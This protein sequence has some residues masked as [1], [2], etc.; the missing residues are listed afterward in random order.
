[1]P[2]SS[3]DQTPDPEPK[4]N[5]VAAR[6]AANNWRRSTKV[7]ER[8][9]RVA[10]LHERGLDQDTIGRR[11]GVSRSTI[12]RDLRRLEVLWRQEYAKIASAERLRS[13]AVHRATDDV[14][15]AFIERHHKDDDRIADVNATM[16]TLTASMREKRY[17][18]KDAPRPHPHDYWGYADSDT[19]LRARVALEEQYEPPANAI[20]GLISNEDD[21]PDDDPKLAALHELHGELEDLALAID[22]DPGSAAVGPIFD[23]VRRRLKSIRSDR[24]L[25]G[26]SGGT[27]D[28]PDPS[29]AAGPHYKLPEDSDVGGGWPAEGPPLPDPT[30]PWDHA[31]EPGAPPPGAD[32]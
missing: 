7:R 22:D 9:L 21:P 6:I 4:P 8:L 20:L 16:R 19:P 28:P 15:L 5:R 2:T 13:L 14:C 25:N 31:A 24:D 12:S 18:L 26:S 3:H 29:I 17:L 11:L 23:R 1:M 30:G 27:S 10:G 32:W